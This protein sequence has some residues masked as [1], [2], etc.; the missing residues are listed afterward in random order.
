[1]LERSAS[2]YERVLLGR[3][4]KPLT[5]NEAAIIPAICRVSRSIDGAVSAPHGERQ[6]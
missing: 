5:Q 3:V 6:C 2:H 1:M 4:C